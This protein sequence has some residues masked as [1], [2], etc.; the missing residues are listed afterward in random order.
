MITTTP[1][2]LTL[3]IC[4][5]MAIT[6]WDQSASGWWHGW[7]VRQCPPGCMMSSPVSTRV[8]NMCDSDCQCQA[9]S[10]PVSGGV[11]H[12]TMDCISIRQCRQNCIHQCLIQ[13][14]YFIMSE[15]WQ[16]AGQGW[17][18]AKGGVCTKWV[19][20]GYMDHAHVHVRRAGECY[21]H[22]KDISSGGSGERGGMTSMPYTL[23]GRVMVSMH[24][25]WG[26][27]MQV[28]AGSGS[29][30]QGWVEARLRHQW[31]PKWYAAWFWVTRLP[32]GMVWETYYY[33]QWKWVFETI[34]VWKK[35]CLR[36]HAYC[37]CSLKLFWEFEGAFKCWD[38]LCCR[39]S[40]GF[41]MRTLELS[42]I[43]WVIVPKSEDGD[44]GFL[45][46]DIVDG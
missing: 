15:I 27:G 12:W 9:M 8:C 20:C 7:Q 39:M 36:W 40:E 4:W 45:G 16:C 22:W 26:K 5:L 19:W 18:K 2:I 14:K 11:Q 17:V 24:V 34:R 3:T 37:S 25:R 46:S 38:F 31:G 6:A 21:V 43:L 42:C 44:C 32:W 1:T 29:G 10:A 41:Y 35:C 30:E 13:V 28:I 33:L 23:G